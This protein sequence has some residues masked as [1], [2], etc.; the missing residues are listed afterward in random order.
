MKVGEADL[1][2]HKIHIISKRGSEGKCEGANRCPPLYEVAVRPQ[3]NITAPL[4][5]TGSM[6]AYHVFFQVS[7]LCIWV[8]W[9]AY[10]AIARLSRH[11]NTSLFLSIRAAS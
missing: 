3:Y 2:T 6:T 1:C 11:S 5:F 10:P 8:I 9:N 4:H 7:F